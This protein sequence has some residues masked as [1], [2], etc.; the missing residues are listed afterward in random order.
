[1]NTDSVSKQW[2]FKVKDKDPQSVMPVS[3]VRTVRGTNRIAGFDTERSW[4]NIKENVYPFT[5]SNSVQFDFSPKRK[6]KSFYL[7]RQADT[8]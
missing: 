7:V 4:K 6:A 3:R 2:K 5:T 1:M 8:N